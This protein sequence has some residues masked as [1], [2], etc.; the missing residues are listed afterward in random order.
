MD[1]LLTVKQVSKILNAKAKTIYS[2]A[3]NGNIPCL[4]ING[5][6]RFV[7][8]EI[9]DWIKSLRVKD[10]PDIQTKKSSQSSVS[11]D[12]IIKKAIADTKKNRYNS[13]HKEKP[14][15]SSPERR[16]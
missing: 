2:W 15:Q 11:I 14:D 6:L 5:L 9:E 10:K 12:N 3:E 4:K 7:P 16:N 1:T 8:A 13:F